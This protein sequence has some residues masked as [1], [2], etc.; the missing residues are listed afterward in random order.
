[1]I[2][3]EFYQVERG[4]YGGTGLGLAITRR[5][6]EEHGGNIWA[7]SQLGKGSTFYFTLPLSVENE[8][9]RINRS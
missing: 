7:T 1:M 2:F 9:G 4:K 6:V 8:D 3:D 5:L